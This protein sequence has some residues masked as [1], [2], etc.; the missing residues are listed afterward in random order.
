MTKYIVKITSV[1]YKHIEAKSEKQ[2]EEFALDEPD[3]K[4]DEFEEYVE[5]GKTF[6]DFYYE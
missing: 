3:K 5:V 6:K 1:T 4:T 2:A